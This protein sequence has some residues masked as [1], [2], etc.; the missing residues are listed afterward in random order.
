MDP[1]DRSDIADSNSIGQE[2]PVMADDKEKTEP[3]K[4]RAPDILQRLALSGKSV[5]SSKPALPE[6]R[7]T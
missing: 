7:T 2:L 1:S 3:V 5:P 6:E 4:P